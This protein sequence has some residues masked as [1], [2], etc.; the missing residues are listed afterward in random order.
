MRFVGA[1]TRRHRWSG[2]GTI[3]RKLPYVLFMSFLMIS[4]E[5]PLV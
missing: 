5:N 4:G 3:S 1:N 2:F